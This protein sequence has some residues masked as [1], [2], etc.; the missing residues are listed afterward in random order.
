MKKLLSLLL[1]MLLM[2]SCTGVAFAQAEEQEALTSQEAASEDFAT[3]AEAMMYKMMDEM[4]YTEVEAISAAQARSQ[5]DV[6]PEVMELAYSDIDAADAR[7][8]EKILAARR[9]IIFQY[10]WQADDGLGFMYDPTTKEFSFTPRFSDLFPGW[11]LPVE[12]G[13]PKKAPV[14][15]E[16]VEPESVTEEEAETGHEPEEPERP[17]DAGIQPQILGGLVLK[18]PRL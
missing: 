18:V 15:P 16:T 8:R 7:Q 5:I 12:P 11:D 17:D 14:E 1:A 13:Y 3:K 9:V 2:V 6:A 10:S 4:G